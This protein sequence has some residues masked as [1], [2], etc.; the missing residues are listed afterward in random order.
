M[1]KAFLFFVSTFL[2]STFILYA[3]DIT[4]LWTGYLSTTEKTLPYE[5]VIS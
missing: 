2:G 5:V 4:G 1:Q 3:Q